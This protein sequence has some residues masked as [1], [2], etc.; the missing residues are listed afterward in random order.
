MQT[1]AVATL[2]QLDVVRE[3]HPRWYEACYV[4]Y[5]A[6]PASEV[7]SLVLNRKWHYLR[8]SWLWTREWVN[9]G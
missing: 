8:A 9:W 2:V 5:I 3:P 6:P 4:Y 7:P 1:K